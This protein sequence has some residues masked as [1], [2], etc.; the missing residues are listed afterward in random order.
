MQIVY[1]ESIFV[2]SGV[3]FMVVNNGSFFTVHRL[4]GGPAESQSASRMKSWPLIVLPLNKTPA[5]NTGRTPCCSGS[6]DEPGPCL[7]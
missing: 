4:E 7:I 6:Q 1:I 5:L 3:F 2:I